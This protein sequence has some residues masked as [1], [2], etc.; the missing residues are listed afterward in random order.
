MSAWLARR[1]L[2]ALLVVFA[3]SV[4][5]YLLTFVA[6]SDPARALAGL[7]SNARAVARIREALGLD[8]PALDQ[9]L[10]YYGRLLSGDLGR[11]YRLNAP[12]ADLLLAHLPATVELAVAGLALGLLLGVPLGVAGA[13]RPGGRIDRLGLVLSSTLV[14]VPGFVLGL[15]M[16]YA[17]AVLPAQL[18][19]I[20]IV[21]IGT[22]PHS[23]LDIRSLALPALA[24][25]LLAMPIYV[26][27]T[28][29]GMLDELAQDHIRTARAKGLGERRVVWRHAFRNV[30]G[31]L[32]AQAGVDLGAFLGGVVVI[33]AV[34]DWPGIGRE[35][36][37]S[38]TGEDLPLLMGTVL[39]ATLCVVLANLAAD[40]LG[41]LVDPRLQDELAER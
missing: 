16:I 18:L 2:W 28:R 21:P 40:L 3:V 23:T 9:L 32:I 27:V 41:A 4:L 13:T 7:H 39:V 38:I 11:S 31:P 36:V 20:R 17:F 10:R 35:A 33:E 8:L 6:P 19:D 14:S 1:V 22:P 26:R 30:L 25:G 24:L 34:F 29:T 12:V 37:R 5:T 15:A